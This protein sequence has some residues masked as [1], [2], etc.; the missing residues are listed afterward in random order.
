MNRSDLEEEIGKL[1]GDK[2]HTR[3]S[4]T[5]IDTR[6]DA[7]E[8][9]VQKWTN[10]VKTATSYTPVASTAEVTVSANII[11]ILRATYTLSDGTV[12]GEKNGFKPISRWELDFSRPNWQNEVAGEPECWTFDASTR[13]VILIPKPDT[14]VSNALTLLEVRQPTTP[15][16]QGTSSSQPFDSNALMVPF[17]RALAYWVV[18]EC[19]KDNQDS[20]SLQK[21]RY[22]RSNDLQRPGEYEK[23]IKQILMKF[24]VPEAI[25]A[26][27]LYQPQGGRISGTGLARKENPLGGL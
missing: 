26:R 11:D 9:D 27:V 24:D 6:L 19:L 16:S 23:E 21:S 13:Q 4:T 12:K 25:P 5:T 2:D 18:S 7:A 14:S 10:A 1:L 17:H 15:L 3:W 20:E 8:L 22:F